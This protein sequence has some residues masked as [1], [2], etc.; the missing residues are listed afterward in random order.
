MHREFRA[1]QIIIVDATDEPPA[2]DTEDATNPD[3]SPKR[4]IVFKA[5]EGFEPPP[6]VEESGRPLTVRLR[7]GPAGVAGGLHARPPARGAR[8]GG[9][10]AR[11]LLLGG[12][13]GGGPC[14]R[15]SACEVDVGVDVEVAENGSG[16]VGGGG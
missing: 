8:G 1:G 14:W 3:G 13:L 5:V 7:H 2:E 11:R 12:R 6:A 9:R 15:A 16:T 4:R 10:G